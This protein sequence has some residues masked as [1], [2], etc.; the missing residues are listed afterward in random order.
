MTLQPVEKAMGL[1]KGEKM[2][3]IGGLIRISSTRKEYLHEITQ[4]ECQKEGFPQITP[5]QF[6]H[7]FCK[8]HKCSSSEEINRIEF[9]YL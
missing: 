9:E 5:E 2:V 3:K 7:L 6:V 8:H 1:K 4:E